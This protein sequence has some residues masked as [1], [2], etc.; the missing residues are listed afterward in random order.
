MASAKGPRTSNQHARRAASNGHGPMA[1]TNY[2]HPT[3]GTAGA[4]VQTRDHGPVMPTR[5]SADPAARARRR[6]GDY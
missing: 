4:A 6:F 3:S 5:V 1:H 2:N